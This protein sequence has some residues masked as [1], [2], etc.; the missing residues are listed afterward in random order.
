MS[1]G[2]QTIFLSQSL[3]E[4]Q[5]IR[6]VFET[7]GVKM[8]IVELESGY[9]IRVLEEAFARAE[10]VL[11]ERGILGSDDEDEEREEEPEIEFEA[12]VGALPEPDAPY[13]ATEATPSSWLRSLVTRLRGVR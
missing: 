10:K 12:G 7:H 6:A 13:R 8:Q 1:N 3:L 9:E 4:V 11:S 2:F 5:M